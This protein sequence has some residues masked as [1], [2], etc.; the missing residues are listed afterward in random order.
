MQHRIKQPV[1]SNLKRE[2][3]W[4]GQSNV[5]LKCHVC[6]CSGINIRTVHTWKAEEIVKQMVTRLQHEEIVGQTKSTAGL[7]L[8]IAPKWCSAASRKHRKAMVVTEVNRIGE[9]YL[10]RAEGWQQ[11]VQWTIWEAH[12][13]QRK[14]GSVCWLVAKQLWCRDSIGGKVI[15]F[16]ISWQRSLR[17]IH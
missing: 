17:Y 15:G 10:I 14:V 6:K 4:F 5:L 9:I 11:Q 2:Y 7:R 12:L 16:C 13:K 8:E 1:G 3:Q